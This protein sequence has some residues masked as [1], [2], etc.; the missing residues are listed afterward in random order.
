MRKRLRL[1]FL[2]GLALVTAWLSTSRPAEAVILCDNLDTKTC[3]L[4]GKTVGC[5]WL[6]GFY[7]S[8][9]CASGHWSCD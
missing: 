1:F 4:E 6:D 2:L 5:R 3:S 7:G 9:T 8:C